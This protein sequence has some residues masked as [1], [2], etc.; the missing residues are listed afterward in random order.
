MA[1]ET[2]MDCFA[3]ANLV[4]RVVVDW[5]RDVRSGEAVR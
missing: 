5:S 4:Q 3:L 1:H 2:H